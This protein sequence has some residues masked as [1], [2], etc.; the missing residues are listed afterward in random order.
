MDELNDKIVV[1]LKK[2]TF[3]KSVWENFSESSN[4]TKDLKINSARI[5]DIVLD[6][7]DEFGIVIKDDAIEKL[8]T[9]AD[10]IK[11]IRP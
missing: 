11:V 8:Y 1:I 6:I 9:I 10:I 5:I 2:Y 7:E 4:I 3:D